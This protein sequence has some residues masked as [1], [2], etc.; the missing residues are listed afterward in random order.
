M[1]V[2]NV[3]AGTSTLIAP[4][5]SKT[6]AGIAAGGSSESISGILIWE[7]SGI[8]TQCFSL[9]Q[10]ITLTFNV[11]I[12]SPTTLS[13]DNFAVFDSDPSGG[14]AVSPT[15]TP[16]LMGATLTLSV[17]RTGSFSDPTSTASGSAVWLKNF[18]VDASIIQAGTFVTATASGTS[19]QLSTTNSIV[20]VGAV[21]AA[22]PLALSAPTLSFGQQIVGTTS[23]PQTV[24]LS[25]NGTLAVSFTNVASSAGF[26]QTNTCGTHLDA[27][28]KCSISATFSPQATGSATGTITI[29]DNATGS[30]H[31]IHL[32]GTGV[33]SPGTPTLTSLTPARV[34]VGGP[35]FQLL[36]QGSNFGPGSTVRVN[37]SPRATT[38]VAIDTL[39]ASILASDIATV[40][41]AVI[42]VAN[43]DAV[44]AASL[45]VQIVANPLP[46][47]RFQY[48]LPHV[49]Q[50]GGFVTKITLTNLSNSLLDNSLV[51]F[52][53]QSGSIVSTVPYSIPPLGTIR[54]TTPVAARFGPAQA[55]QWAVVGSQT[56]LGVNLFYELTDSTGKSVLNTVGFNNTTPSTD[57]AIPVELE[58]P[59]A[60]GPFNRTVGVAFANMSDTPNQITLQLFNSAGIGATGKYVFQ[61]APYAQT[62]IDLANISMFAAAV[63]SGNWVGTLSIAATQPVSSIALVDDI[64]PFASTPPVIGRANLRAA[65][66]AGICPSAAELNEINHELTILF[67]SDPT[68][69]ALVC[70]A[71]EGSLDL[72]Q[73]QLRAYQA[74]R[75][76]RSVN[77]DA[78]LPFSSKRTIY[79]WLRSAISGIRFRGDI[80]ASGCCNSTGLLDI[81]LTSSTPALL[82]SGWVG[83]YLSGIDTGL[84]TMAGEIVRFA[85]ISEGVVNSCGALDNTIAEVGPWAVAMDWQDFIANHASTFFDDTASGEPTSRYRDIAA[86]QALAYITAG[87]SKFCTSSGIATVQ[88]RAGVAFG[89]HTLG[90]PPLLRSVTVNSTTGT[91]FSGQTST[92]TGTNS[93]DF[94][95]RKDGCDGQSV[96]PSCVVVVAFQPGSLGSRSAQLNVGSAPVIAVPLSGDGLAATPIPVAPYVYYLPHVITGNGFVTKIT[97]SNQANVNNDVVVQFLTQAGT[98]A[99]S[100][101]YAIAGGGALRV[102]TPESTRFGAATTQW[103]VVGAT[104]PL[105]AN[106]FFELE[107][108]SSKAIINTIGFNSSDQLSSFSFPVEFEPYPNGTPGGRTAG[109]AM[110]NPLGI[111]NT[112]VMTLYSASGV[113][114][115]T[116]TGKIPAYGQ[117]AIDLALVAEFK[118][119]LPNANFVGSVQV[120]TTSG[121]VVTI[122][123]EDDFGPF[124]AT[125]VVAVPLQ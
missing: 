99:Q 16:G 65:E 30:P 2:S 56:P 20:A 101:R 108:A 114:M 119:V 22:G 125:P 110:A 82:T 17:S 55:P 105:L 58:R 11:P 87:T 1:A 79:D 38:F 69:G 122:A 32:D 96:P 116:S 28:S 50:G 118:S 54:L 81:S 40:G 92:I 62:A 67:E 8:G 78:P 35:D 106:L 44:S 100:T 74:L 61:L 72:T 41:S 75:V 109:L 12:A 120:K 90:D 48:A 89:S 45:T 29:Q 33:A 46:A 102:A 5:T 63:P 24:Q 37:G 113:A 64:G 85:R 73:A 13:L 3:P 91:S 25:N 121:R 83:P 103:V 36:V 10:V 49:V 21:A 97:L 9:N 84:E 59:V 88:P 23:N 60:N 77:F 27:G 39:K 86:R 15:L 31:V 104:H 111:E 47:T 51:V 34:I 117:V 98:V 57:M 6:P 107:D 93:D 94:T 14:L 112:Y 66:V 115:A 76:L 26:A 124:S 70:R 53:D 19:G 43:T 4:D 7:D 123:L 18:K 80:T 95:I 71:A 68:A 42:T 52:L